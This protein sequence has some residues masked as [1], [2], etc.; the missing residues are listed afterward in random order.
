MTSIRKLLFFVIA[1]ASA[2]FA[3]PAQAATSGKIIGLT[4]TQLSPT[5]VRTTVQNLTP[6]GNSNVS[7]FTVLVHSGGTIVSLIANVGASDGASGNVTVAPDGKS[8]SVEN[9]SSTPLQFMETYSLDLQVTGG[10][11]TCPNVTTWD[12]IG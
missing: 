3:L 10:A 2:A 4:V 12:A 9:I 11:F 1:L 6:A 8:V 7:S 5:T